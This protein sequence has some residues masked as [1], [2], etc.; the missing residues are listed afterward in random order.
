MHLHRLLHIFMPNIVGYTVGSSRSPNLCESV[1]TSTYRILVSGTSVTSLSTAFRTGRVRATLQPLAVSTTAPA[2][3]VPPTLLYVPFDPRPYH[4]IKPS[5]TTCREA[6]TTPAPPIQTTTAFRASRPIHLSPCIL[7][8]TPRHTARQ[9]RHRDHRRCFICT[10]DPGPRSHAI[11][12]V[13]VL[14]IV[15]RRFGLCIGMTALWV[16]SQLVVPTCVNLGTKAPLARQ[17]IRASKRPGPAP[18]APGQSL[19]GPNSIVGSPT[20]RS[21]QPSESYRN[22]SAIQQKRF[23]KLTLPRR[24]IKFT[25]RFKSVSRRYNGDRELFKLD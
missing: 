8:L 19:P 10:I 14:C 16:H 24:D 17:L 18:W 5:E 4:S 21:R 9:A 22:L 6:P 11:T 3:A 13:L 20:G 25:R 12:P 23:I 15:L 7:W 1:V 2:C